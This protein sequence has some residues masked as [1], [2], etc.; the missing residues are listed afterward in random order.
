M[1]SKTS[2]FRFGKLVMHRFKQLAWL[3]TL[4]SVALF[5]ILPVLQGMTLGTNK[6]YLQE[7]TVNS[8]FRDNPFVPIGALV[9]G[10]ITACVVLAFMNSKTRNDLWLSLP[11]RRE[12]LYIANLTA[13]GMAVLLPL[14]AAYVLTI[15]VTVLTPN[16]ASALDFSAVLSSYLSATGLFLV[17]YSMTVFWCVISGRTIIAVLCAIFT[18]E[19]GIA[20]LWL[21]TFL[22]KLEFKTFYVSS[23]I[24]KA[25]IALCPFASYLAYPLFTQVNDPVYL[26][27]Q[28]VWAAVSIGLLFLSVLLYK[29]RPTE[30][31]GNALVY[32]GALPVVKYPLI[33]IASGFGWL[34]F[35]AATGSF[36]WAAF[37]AVALGL[38]VFC[39][40]NV[41]EK[42]EFRNI[43]HHW[44]KFIATMAVFG[45]CVSVLI[46][47]PFSFDTRL[48]AR[49]KITEARVY[50]L[51][52]N[53]VNLNPENSGQ[54]ITDPEIIDSLYN[55]SKLLVSPDINLNYINRLGSYNNF[56]DNNYKGV[57]LNYLVDYNGFTRQYSAFV[58]DDQ[59]K[60]LYATFSSPKVILNTS[61]AYT[62]EP[63]EIEI[64]TLEFTNMNLAYIVDA[65]MATG[66]ESGGS[67]GDV[68]DALRSDVLLGDAEKSRDAHLLCV[69]HLSGEN[70]DG[71]VTVN[72][73]I[74][75]YF[76]KIR[77][78][79]LWPVIEDH[80]MKTDPALIESIEVEQ[81]GKNTSVTYTDP[82]IIAELALAIITD[83]DANYNPLVTVSSRYTLTVNYKDG[84]A[85]IPS[86]CNERLPDWL[87]NS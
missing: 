86:L 65:T 20:L 64:M 87:K 52:L 84:T 1:T 83:E 66:P 23:G 58:S 15:I 7:D 73:P 16:A 17:A 18:P 12:K 27:M 77:G 28:T 53:K 38:C 39:L 76:E 41:L 81:N 33:L 35:K 68:I 4:W 75:D 71:F 78:T 56:A 3:T 55:L 21:S 29:K 54:A 6:G 45:L 32:P 19:I 74:Y 14:T 60:L 43:L 80:M 85:V 62:F 59:A 30:K 37:G 42:F 26:I 47:D 51:M 13:G 31:A 8:I 46:L 61:K 24:D 2:S 70:K 40:V 25:M 49:E 57:F 67:V 69:L 22:C 50:Q 44:W 72:V 10:I 63:N 82:V 5:F 79:W 34:F 48:P 11:V 36:V 9:I